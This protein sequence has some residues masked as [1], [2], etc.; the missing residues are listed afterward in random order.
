M[1]STLKI[2]HKFYSENTFVKKEKTVEFRENLVLEGKSLNGKI[3]KRTHYRT[4]V[5]NGV[6]VF[7]GV[8]EILFLV[9]KT[10]FYWN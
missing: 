4:I 3:Y 1:F 10:T 8:R 7:V 6:E 9:V 2:T 5:L